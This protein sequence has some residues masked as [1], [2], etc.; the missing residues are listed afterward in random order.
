[1]SEAPAVTRY[2]AISVGDQST[3]VAEFVPD[4]AR[5]T[6]YQSEAELEAAFVELLQ[7]QAYEYLRIPSESALVANLRA[8][9]EALN[10]IEF[11]GLRIVLEGITVLGVTHLAF[12]HRDLGPGRVLAAHIGFLKRVFLIK[13]RR[14]IRCAFTN[15]RIRN[16]F[17][18]FIVIEKDVKIVC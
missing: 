12:F 6:A 3:V 8:Q 10:R 2:E 11:P 5:E 14:D 9:L 16:G 7:S 4:G 18:K 17:G 1:M 15:R 13:N